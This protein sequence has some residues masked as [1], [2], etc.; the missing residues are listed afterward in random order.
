MSKIAENPVAVLRPGTDTPTYT[1]TEAAE[2]LGMHQKSL[3]RWR[4]MDKLAD[5]V[6]VH[7][8]TR[9]R[10]K[11]VPALYDASTIRAIADGHADLLA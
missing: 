4:L 6:L 1:E 8:T 11:G 7:Q 3:A 9:P 5:G 2:L 10:S